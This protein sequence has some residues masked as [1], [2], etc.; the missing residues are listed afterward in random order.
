MAD[1]IKQKNP[2][3]FESQGTEKVHLGSD[4]LRLSENKPQ[5]KLAGGKS[6]NL[7]GNSPH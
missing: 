4:P 6:H 5:A 1:S 7:Q 2:A 3:I